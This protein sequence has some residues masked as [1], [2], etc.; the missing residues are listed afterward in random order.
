MEKLMSPT[1]YKA[2]LANLS[3]VA[4][5]LNTFKPAM[6]M[7]NVGTIKL[8]KIKAN[9]ETARLTVQQTI[10]LRKPQARQVVAAF[11]KIHNYATSLEDAISSHD[12]S[13][14]DVKPFTSSC[15]SL[16]NEAS[17]ELS[18]LLEKK[19]EVHSWQEGLEKLVEESSGIDDAMQ[20]APRIINKYNRYAAKLPKNAITNKNKFVL[21]E[22]PVIPIFSPFVTAEE[23][24]SSDIDVE[25]LG[26]YAIINDQTVVAINLHYIRQE[27]LKVDEYFDLILKSIEKRTN[28][29]WVQVGDQV[30]ATAGKFT[31][32]W[33]MPETEYNH[34]TK[35]GKKRITVTEWGFP[36]KS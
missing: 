32:F 30:G 34:L 36:F 28:K 9:L 15:L 21:L 14:D 1:A 4:D 35:V 10:G 17:K 20:E 25:R 7:T 26:T 13:S 19:K 22:L 33:I 8:R 11:D 27:K 2:V 3:I 12:V 16:V 31:Y 23:L 29:R 18:E 5:K 6:V 24:K